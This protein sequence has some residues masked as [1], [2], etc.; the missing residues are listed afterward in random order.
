V[1]PAVQAQ[2]DNAAQVIEVTAQ[3]RLERLQDVPLATSVVSAKDLE[4]RGIEDIASLSSVAPNL[5]VTLTP[6]NATAAQISIRGSVTTNPALFWEP[7]VGLYVDGVYLGKMQGSVFDLVDLERVEVLRGPQGTLYGRNT[8][9]G[10]VNLVT[11][12]PGGE[13]LASVTLE[14]GND[15]ARVGKVSMDLPALGPLK[16]GLGLRSE[17]RDGWVRTA[18][19][20]S[21]SSLNDR[22]TQGARVAATL[23]LGRDLSLDYRY[24]RSRADQNSR[25]SQVIR[26]TVDQD[27]GFTSGIVVSQGRQDQAAVDGPSFER[28]RLSGHAL[29]GEWR[30]GA[31]QTVKAILARRTMDWDDGLDLDG[32]PVAFA[33]TQ[34]LSDYEQKTAE[35]QWLGG[36]GGFNWVAG[37]YRLED[38]GFT[39]N[40]Q[41]FFYGSAVFDSRYG[42]T[43]QANAVYGQIDTRLSERLTLTAGLRR[44]DEDKTI[45]RF[46][47]SGATTLI[48]GTTAARASF[49]A[50]TPALS[51]AWKASDQLNLYAR[52]AEGFKSGGFNGE[53][54]DLA[55]TT[56]PYRPEKQ[57]TVELGAKM[58]LGGLGSVNVALFDNRITD[59]QRSVFTAQGSA[60]SN[61]RNVGKAST[62]GLEVETALRPLRGLRLQLNYGY[63]DARHKEYLE[64]GANV[65]GNRAV[66]HAPRHT[67]NAVIDAELG[68]AAY[69][70]W[71][72]VADYAWSSSYYLYPYPFSLAPGDTPSQLAADTRVKSA[73]FLNLRLVLANVALGGERSLDASLWVRNA[74]DKQHVGNLIDFGPGFGNLTQ[75][76]YVD[77]RS[78]G[79]AATLKF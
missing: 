38:D 54:Q 2:S 9:A 11:R 60:A 69:G 55:E 43:T 24:D 41:T 27:F 76:Y 57:K 61:I 23:D 46:L 39:S 48:P 77:P 14:A 72:A 75:A 15:S 59:L 32:S 28:M 29:T 71:R 17:K 70:S 5:K 67:V 1:S 34:R 51:L 49:S 33:H 78:Y 18:P 26:S 73:G 79:I 30:P 3:R 36:S 10:A 35:L 16:L 53:A 42:F 8:L 31:T 63:L 25:F 66:V 19:G 62:R 20:S 7:T 22:D 45:S 21:A 37:V 64:L 47:A 4:L 50:T 44:S 6:G 58:Q 68:R 74:L 65:A 12:K 56:T 13:F 40:P 52:Y